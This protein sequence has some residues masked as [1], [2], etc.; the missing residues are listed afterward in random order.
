M[1]FNPPAYGPKPKPLLNYPYLEVPPKVSYPGIE[2]ESI[3][4]KFKRPPSFPGLE[5]LPKIEQFPRVRYP[6]IEVTLPELPQSNFPMDSL[7]EGL[8]SLLNSSARTGE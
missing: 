2:R 3:L 7:S 8:A 4:S 6:G 5:L 1:I